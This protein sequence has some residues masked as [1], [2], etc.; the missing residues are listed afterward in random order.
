LE[1]A[2][3]T[4]G[5]SAWVLKTPTGLPDW[6]SNVSSASSRRSVSTMRSKACQSRAARPMPP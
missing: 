5:A 2:I 6:T 3:S 1:L 4:R